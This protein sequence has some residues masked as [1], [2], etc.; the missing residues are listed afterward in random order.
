M[1]VEIMCL[2]TELA[3]SREEVNDTH[4]EPLFRPRWVELV[5]TASAHCRCHLLLCHLG[6]Y[7]SA[8]GNTL[9]VATILYL[10]Q[11]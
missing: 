1:L 4:A 11:S 3:V 7:L 6:Y 10:K 5:S 9:M 8:L 2:C